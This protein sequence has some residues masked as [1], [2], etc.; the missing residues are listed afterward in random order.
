MWKKKSP[1]EFLGVYNVNCINVNWFSSSKVMLIKTILIK[2]VVETSN[3][4]AEMYVCEPI[5]MNI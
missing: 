5:V 3:F 4:I 2:P 1:L